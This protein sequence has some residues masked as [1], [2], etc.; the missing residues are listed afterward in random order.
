MSEGK[1]PQRVNV[2]PKGGNEPLYSPQRDLAY[3]YAPAMKEA[4]RA[5]DRDQWTETFKILITRLQLTEADISAAVGC[6]VEAHKLFV[7]VPTIKTAEDALVQ[8]GW[9]ECHFGARYLIYGRL[10]EVI[11]GGFF[12][13]L[14]DV[15]PYA[16]ESAQQHQI[17][18]F[19]AEGVGV[20]NRLSKQMDTATPAGYDYRHD[21]EVARQELDLLR[22]AHAEHKAF[23]AESYKVA[24]DRAHDENMR[25][26]ANFKALGD[27][28][29]AYN[30]SG[31][32]SRVWHAITGARIRV[33]WPDKETTNSQPSE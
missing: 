7:N 8:A 22:K 15:S 25:A 9:Y 28:L 6:I 11:L 17:A 10:G 1:T 32:W 24:V 14:R 3:I 12:L 4:I 5:L 33:N 27:A 20:A 31:F 13:A 2:R 19:I 18:D 30:T 21:A 16:D 29:D 26:H 23:A